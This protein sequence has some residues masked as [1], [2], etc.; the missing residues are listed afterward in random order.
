MLFYTGRQIFSLGM[1]FSQ[2]SWTTRW[3]LLWTSAAGW[4]SWGPELKQS[5]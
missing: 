1:P 2:G 3:D 5:L 4:H